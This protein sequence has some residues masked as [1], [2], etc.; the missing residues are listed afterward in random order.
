[1]F[2]LCTNSMIGAYQTSNW[3]S[4]KLIVLILIV[5]SVVAWAV[6]VTKYRE[7]SESARAALRF[8]NAYRKEQHP[9][10]IFM[11]HQSV[12]T[13]P[14]A[15]IYLAG[16]SALGAET[17]HGPGAVPAG[18]NLFDG[19]TPPS[20]SL[21]PAQ[22]EMVRRAVERTVDDEVL[23][24]EDKMGLLMSAISI[25]PLLG[26]L[27]TVWGVLEA[28]W[29]MAKGGLAN[30]SAVAPGISGALLTTVVGL[31]VAIPST[32]GYNIITGK[33]RRLTVQM[34]NF[35]QEFVSTLQR[36]YGRES[37]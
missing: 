11:R 13:S 17:Q 5:F 36:E 12:P 31:L 1:M 35:A 37:K 32:F 30:L 21:T 28:F 18:T 25:S 34:D 2:F 9:L 27:G 33:I 15:K 7:V 16:C 22:L 3:L 8:L 6:M 19:L 24:L 26:L 20:I 14:P 29:E 4:G 23:V 10:S